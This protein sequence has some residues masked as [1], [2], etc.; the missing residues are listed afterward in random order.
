MVQDRAASFPPQGKI[1]SGRDFRTPRLFIDEDLTAEAE[2]ALSRDQMNYVRN[3][4]RLPASAGLL[5]FNGRD[6]EW[7]RR[8]L[9]ARARAGYSEIETQDP[10]PTAHRTGPFGIGALKTARPP[11]MGVKWGGVGGG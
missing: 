9:V 7:R 11:V 8:A 1:M 10:A 5:V 3:V 6:G 2:I 4:L